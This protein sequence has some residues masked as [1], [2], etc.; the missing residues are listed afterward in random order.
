MF[1]IKKQVRKC[2]CCYIHILD[3]TPVE[4]IS[5]VIWSKGELYFYRVCD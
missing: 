1:G 2:V 4:F 5:Q 3:I